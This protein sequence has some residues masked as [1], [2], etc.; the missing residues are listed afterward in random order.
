MSIARSW[1]SGWMK[2]SERC[3]TNSEP[4]QPSIAVTDGSAWVI[5]ETPSFLTRT[6]RGGGGAISATWSSP[7]VVAP[8]ATMT[9]TN[10]PWS[11]VTS[12]M[13]ISASGLAAPT[14]ATAAL[15]TPSSWTRAQA[16]I[17]AS[18]WEGCTRS[19]PERA[20]AMR[21]LVSGT[22]SGIPTNRPS[23][24]IAPTKASGCC[25]SIARIAASVS[26]VS[27]CPAA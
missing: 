5:A 22:V 20:T 26:E 1:S 3:P 4:L 7:A 6:M 23:P 13:C 17:T 11:R 27:G 2:S 10:T 12:K 16:L 15:A 9:P 21:W 25:A 24:S 14:R 18:R 19:S 8:V